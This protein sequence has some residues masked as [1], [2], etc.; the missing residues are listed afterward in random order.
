MTPKLSLSQKNMQI[1]IKA[2]LTSVKLAM[3]NVRMWL[4]MRQI[5]TFSNEAQMR[6]M[7]KPF[8][9]GGPFCVGGT[10]PSKKK[11]A[12]I[13]KNQYFAL[14]LRILFRKKLNYN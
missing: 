1:P 3:W 2:L 11:K 4:S 9:C 5:G 12:K 6:H 14:L 7:N 13:T 10:T 8:G